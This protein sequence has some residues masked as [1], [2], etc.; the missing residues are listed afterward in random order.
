MKSSQPVYNK[1]PVGMHSANEKNESHVNTEVV[2][3]ATNH[4]IRQRISWN[5]VNPKTNNRNEC[6]NRKNSGPKDFIG[7]I[8]HQTS[9]LSIAWLIE[10]WMIRPI[11]SYF[12]KHSPKSRTGWRPIFNLCHKN[13]CCDYGTTRLKSRSAEFKQIFLSSASCYNLLNTL[14]CRR[15]Q[16]GYRYSFDGIITVCVLPKTMPSVFGRQ[17]GNPTVRK[18]VWQSVI[19]G[20]SSQFK[21]S[22]T[23]LHNGHNNLSRES[24]R[25]SHDRYFLLELH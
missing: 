24:E 22:P 8:Y 1:H 7:T 21:S 6:D 11:H 2:T 4:V 20:Y 5:H 18:D 12:G 15:S 23:H 10:K 19:H 3:F 9:F 16:A 14:S 17:F 25:K 13:R